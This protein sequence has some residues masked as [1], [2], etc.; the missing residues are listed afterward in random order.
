[1][2]GHLAAR[3]GLGRRATVLVEFAV[4][5]PVF[6]LMLFM[7]FDFSYD[8]FL[9]SVLDSAVQATARQIEVGGAQGDTKRQS[10]IT[11]ALCPNALGLLNCNNLYVRVESIIQ[12]SCPGGAGEPDLYDAT[13]GEL[14]QTGK[15]VL[16]LGLYGGTGQAGPTAC[17]TN[18]SASG[19]CVAGPGTS[20]DPEIIILSAVYLAPSFLGHL[21]LQSFT[22]QGH[23]VRPM[24]SSAAFI[25]EAFTGTYTGS[26]PC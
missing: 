16:G 18:N 15:G 20:K 2:H 24:F 22:Y 21:V 11:N 25:T 1:L 5:G 13:D 26:N 10:L 14:P 23:V 9:N 17:E 3:L 12:S 7:A 6:F 8:S 4:V 19:F